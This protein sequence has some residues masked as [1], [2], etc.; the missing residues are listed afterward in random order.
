MNKIYTAGSK[1]VGTSKSLGINYCTANIYSSMVIAFLFLPIFLINSFSQKPSAN[2]SK[3]FNSIDPVLERSVRNTLKQS[4][5]KLQLIENNGQGDL[6]TDV[7]AYFSSANETVFIEKN[8]LRI[9]VAEKISQEKNKDSKPGK[10]D[11]SYNS[12]NILFKGSDG[13]NNYQ[14]EKPFDV[15]RNFI[16]SGV[17]GSEVIKAQSYGEI[18]LKDMYPGIDLRLYSQE[19][20]HLEFDWIIWPGADFSQINM[21]F[22]GQ[23]KLLINKNG[24]LLIKLKKGD[25]TM[26]LPESYWVT[27]QGKQLTNVQFGLKR[28]NIIH[29][30]GI[31]KKQNKY[32]LVIDPDLLW[33]TF[34]DGGDANFD[35][36]LYAIDF[37]PGN[38]LLYC[39]GAAS[40]QVSTVYAAALSGAWNGTFNGIP[41]ALIYALSKD[42]Q[43]VTYITYLGGANSDVAIGLSLSNSFVYTCGYTASNDFPVTKAA[44]G[45]YP[46][47]DSVY[48]ANNDGFVSVFNLTLDTLFYCSYLGGIGDDMALTIRAVQDSSFYISLVCEADI[49]AVSPDYLSNYADN[50]FAGSSEAWIGK[51]DSFNL[52]RFGTYIGGTSKDLVNDFQVLSDGDVIFAGNTQQ[53]DEVNASIADNGTGQEVLFGRINVPASG[54]VNFDLIE[55]IGGSNNDMGWGVISLGDSVSVI[56]GQTNS[57]NFPLGAGTG[58][59]TTRQ[60]N[61]DAFLC[62][63]NNDGSGGYN[64]T[65][66][67][68]S[69]VDILVSVR[70]VLLYNDIAL[71]SFGSTESTDLTTF[72]IDQG[73]LFSNALTGGLDMMF[74]ICD[75]SLQSKYYLSY[76]GGTANDYLGKTGAPI[77]SNHLYFNDADSALYLGTTTHS[78]DTTQLPKYVGRGVADIANTGVPVFDET[79]GNTGNDTHTI[80]AISTKR[81]FVVLPLKWVSFGVRVLADCSAGLNWK[82]IHEQNVIRYTIERSIDGRAFQEIGNLPP[83]QQ[84]YYY[85]DNTTSSLVG[86]VYYRVIAEET[87]NK[88][89]FSNIT[90]V[91]LCD[92]QGTLINIYP[93]VIT[94]SF[95]V[96]GL[97]NALAKNYIIDVI[98]ESGKK[99]TSYKVINAAVAENF[100]INKKPAGAFYF[101]IIKDADSGKTLKT[102]KVL[103]G[104]Q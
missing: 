18:T 59:Q 82:T 87:G 23:Q 50:V 34:F 70:P 84:N 91:S 38:S 100:Y 86:N 11:Y 33:G 54:S 101:I 57:N 20:G 16:S 51:F 22:T 65:Y 56:V 15:K 98:D 68:G 80:L 30:T 10:E 6:S 90:T 71:M 27:P 95:T 76:L 83:G 96:S 73:P 24:E 41:D 21:E 48:H 89:T 88:K 44:N 77:G 12:F 62:K 47:F 94:N 42:G 78:Y 74:L 53:V 40:M 35:E 2:N 61:Y 3:T 13:F 1:I 19:N 8:R 79:K 52:L 14:K 72:N 104:T 49:S 31:S 97:S 29:F 4:S 102:Q 66:V 81:L 9:V 67:G 45:D 43:F 75:L 99:I 85:N 92:R 46:A 37:N 60:G 63:L 93:T 32:P 7:I 103:I 64:A 39:A 55:K 36:Y 25:F 26:R 69:D 28:K 5:L 17:N 58:F